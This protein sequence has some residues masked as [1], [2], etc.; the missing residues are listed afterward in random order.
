[1][2]SGCSGYYEGDCDDPDAD[3]PNAV[4]GAERDGRWRATEREARWFGDAATGRDEAWE[5]GSEMARSATGGLDDYEV[6]VSAEC[7]IE[8]RRIR[9]NCHRISKQ[10]APEGMEIWQES[11]RE[12]ER[13][14]AGSANYYQTRWQFGLERP[15]GSGSVG[16]C[17]MWWGLAGAT[18][19]GLVL[20]LAVG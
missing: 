16:R 8:R 10:E 3:D 15:A 9:S 7:I 19:L 2:C 17:L 13:S 14:L 6:L 18:A 1:M 5:A 20:W 12:P 4:R 11:Q